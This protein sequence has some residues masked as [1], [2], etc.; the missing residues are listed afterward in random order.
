MQKHIGLGVVT[1][2]I[3]APSAPAWGQESDSSDIDEIIVTGEK[4]GRTLQETT[5]SVAVLTGDELESRS[6]ED[7]Y[8]AI[9]R[10]PNVTQSFGEKG[11]TIRGIDQRLGAGG[12]LLINTIVDGASLPNNQ[13][14]FFGPY[15]AWDLGQVEVLRGPQGTVQ[16][17]NAI[18]GAIVINSADPIL[19]QWSGKL[20][21]SYG[22][23]GS[24]QAA[25]A[26][27][28]PV[29]EDRLAFRFSADQRESDGWVDNP[30]R[31]EDYDARSALTLRGK[32]L[33]R[34][35][36]TFTAK[37]TLS[38]TDS[39]GG[40]DLVDLGGFPG[41]RL[42]F[43]NGPAEEGSEHLINTLELN[44]DVSDSVSITSLTTFYQHDY[45]RVEDVD[46]SPAALGSIDRVQDDS[47]FVQEV[48][49]TIDTGAGWRALVGAY[50]GDFDNSSFDTITVPTAFLNPQLPPG[51][52]FQERNFATVEENIALFGEAEFDLTDSITLITG[53]RYDNESRD[54]ST[55]ST[56]STDNALVE[57]F[58]PPD[59]LLNNDTSFDALLPKVGIRFG[60]SDATSLGFVAQRAYR[61]GGTGVALVSGEISEFDP[62]YTWTY[63]A[64][65]RTS[66]AGGTIG[67]ETNVFYTE[68]EDQIVTQ[69]TPF[70]RANGIPID[71]LPV[72]AGQS[73]LYGFELSLDAAITDSFTVYGSVGFV[74]TEF[75]DFVTADAELSGNEFNN[76]S[77]VTA[78]IGF[79]WRNAAG[80]SVA[81]DVNFR[82][83]YFSVSDNDPARVTSADILNDAGVVI[84]QRE[85]CSA[86]PCNDPRTTVDSSVVANL[87]AGYS[88]DNWSVFLFARNLFDEEY[89]TQRNAPGG[90]SPIPQGRTAEPRV[91]GI[92][93]NWFFGE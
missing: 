15:S 21:A 87:K 65:V 66:Y 79:S 62:E 51:L 3:I 7:L 73:E 56:T 74:E 61:A 89:L 28:I 31:N 64:S 54:F 26:I 17:R 40:E 84:G 27:N 42:N 32:G 18:G 20:R 88:Q 85:V 34:V 68:W 8:D 80:F 60:V 33:L 58:L 14:T 45:V 35:T 16:G 90:F 13:S 6:V 76:A 25:G 69:I 72:N 39:S 5:T 91:A 86:E 36:D 48:R 11:F 92:E 41:D 52:I 55:L 70:G 75:T 2:L 43:S 47:S 24:Y 9:L 44:W 93:V 53:L 38:F 82:D 10:T 83:E 4:F 57:P 30:T 63:E 23:L 78:S 1:C 22:E 19:D 59:E 29:I 67:L 77:P 49:A 81:G 50:Y 46:N 71:T 12:G 37:Y